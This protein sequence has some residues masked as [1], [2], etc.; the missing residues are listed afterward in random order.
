MTG[1]NQIRAKLLEL[2]GGVFQRLCDDWLHRKGYENINAIGMMQSTDRVRKGTPDCLF[3]QPDGYYVFSEYTVQQNRLAS[4]LEDDI[5]KCFDEQKTGIKS[6]QISEIIICYL[7]EL[8]TH[9]INHLK[10]LC[11]NRNVRLSLN[12]LDSISLSIQNCYPVLSEQYLGLPLDTGQLLSVNDFIIR[13]GKNNLTTSIDNKMLFQNEAIEQGIEQLEQGPLL[14]VSGAAG[15]GKTLFSVNLTVAMQER[16]SDLKVYCLFDKGADLIR[17]ITAHFS[18]PGD[19][20]VFIDDANRLDN[21]L[22]YILHYLNENDG[23]RT[24][25]IIATVRDYARDSVLSQVNKFTE[26]NEQNIAPLTDEQIKELIVELFD[27]NNSE[28]QQRIQEISGGNARLAIMASKVAIETNQIDSIQNVASLYDDYFGQNENIKEVVENE[29]LMAV[30]CAIS[31][32]RKVDKLN[33]SHM[34]WVQNSFGISPE[35]FWEYVG[36][37]HKNELVDLYEN[38][39]VKISDQ[40]LSTYLFYLSVFEKKTIPF[41][42]IVNDFY[43]DFKR[44]IV[45]ALNPVI[46]SFDHK[47]IVKEIR[48]EIEETFKSI[49]ESGNVT[50]SIEFLNSFWFALPTETLIFAQRLISEMPYIEGSWENESF[51]EAKGEPSESSL[52]TLL[53]NF[54]NFGDVEF[55]MSFDLLL[56]YVQKSKESLGH[57]IKELTAKYN[58]KPNDW[59]YGYYIQAHVVDTLIDRSEDGENYLFSKL[60]ILVAKSF[61]KIEYTEHQWN[62][63]DTIRMI[64][65]RLSPDEYLMPI[66]KKLIANLSILQ[67]LSNYEKIVQE[68]FQE[69][70][71]RLRF[72]GKEMAEADLP[73]IKEF[74][75]INLDSNNTSH[76]LIMQDLCEHLD[77]LE[78]EY[79]SEWKNEFASET[80]EL[81]N[82]LIED[83][84]E[85]R[86]LDMGHEEY[87][88]Y[89]HQCFVKYF[90]VLTKEQFTHFMEQCVSLHKALSGRERDYSLNR[91][92]E[93]SLKALAETH[94]KRF[95]E[96]VVMYID[97]DDIFS[98]YPYPIISNL[99]KNMDNKGV[100]ALI[101]SKEYNCRK[102]WCSYYFSLLPEEYISNGE[103]ELMLQHFNDIESHELTNWLDFLSKYRVVDKD[104]YAKVVNI[105]VTKSKSD[106]NY[107]RPL[108]HIFST[109]SEIFDS[110]FEVFE[111]DTGLV[112]DA[113]LAAFK[114]ERYWDYR[115]ETLDILTNRNAN[116]L[117]KIVDCIYENERWPSSHTNMPE[118][119]FLW[120]RDNYVDD[121]EQYAKCVYS[122]E[123][124]SYGRRDNIFCKLFLKEKGK[125]DDNELVVKKQTFIKQSILNNI[126]DIKYS[127]F[128]F[129]V[130]NYMSED[131]RRELLSL[132][133]QNN[134]SFDDFQV[135]DYELT[136]RSWS[137][138]RVPILEKEKNYLVSILPLLNR[139]ELL[140]HR[141]YVE[142]QIEYKIKSIECEKKR[143][144]LESRS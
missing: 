36:V 59:R 51:E 56:Q 106:I 4:K 25:R 102:Y 1:T 19:Y 141:G 85:Q 72:E 135:L 117:N 16:N 113:Y 137:G 109:N 5:S 89:R 6:D 144:F 2:E 128:L 97:Y 136:T 111:S 11:Q 32:F 8:T 55:K 95:A 76:C 61:L 139:I 107:A 93:M 27:I 18:E 41:S 60:F 98:V 103:V 86:M 116:F 125:T 62:R 119:D 100:W 31:F 65:F 30:V 129:N 131:F 124:D 83:R 138:S 142:K 81:S 84:H 52:V 10:S 46:S 26:V 120:Q 114:L 115:G 24:F 21:R 7:G 43:H 75:V 69:Y 64:T 67:R 15:V 35:E 112:F 38:E 133:L 108:G 13:Y 99:F 90:S 33:D 87:N 82:L 44:T 34:D 23:N 40:V 58:F 78:I 28:Y 132:F 122:K 105:L 17:D 57:I 143:D 101:N 127:C 79:P 3:I 71:N 9:E 68:I 53:S 50:S 42:L 134:M 37:L 123:K 66:R 88:K 130:A 80:L 121:I 47:K 92:I 118:L 22:D 14:L 110:W 126:D 12:G 29:K 104:I 91:G 140:E 45:D 49:S 77:S 39:V 74:F 63:G 20:M 73:Y 54:R 70:V 96:I 94:P 48:C